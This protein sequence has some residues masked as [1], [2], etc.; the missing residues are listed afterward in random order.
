MCLAVTVGL[1]VLPELTP[2]YR[3][4]RFVA[5][6]W[7]FGSAIGSIT[8]IAYSIQFAMTS[9]AMVLIGLVIG[10]ITATATIVVLPIGAVAA[11]VPILSGAVVVAAMYRKSAGIA[12]A[13]VPFLIFLLRLT[14][15]TMISPSPAWL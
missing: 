7:V 3:L 6:A 5:V 13:V 9:R 11:S 12:F 1:L 2:A 8:L 14:I 10:N 4:D 15:G